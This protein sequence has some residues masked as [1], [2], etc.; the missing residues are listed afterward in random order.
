MEAFELDILMNSARGKNSSKKEN[1]EDSVAKLEREM[2]DDIRNLLRAIGN[3]DQVLSAS[4]RAFQKL[5]KEC[6]KAVYFTLRK[7]VEKEKENALLHLEVMNKFE[8]TVLEI[9]V[10]NDINEFIKLNMSDVGAMELSSQALSLLSDLTPSHP[11]STSP[12][13]MSGSSTP[14]GSFSTPSRGGPSLT[15]SNLH[16]AASA[17]SSAAAMAGDSF[18]SPLRNRSTSSASS[19]SSGH[20]NAMPQYHTP[21]AKLFAL[22]SANAKQS[23]GATNDELASYLTQIFYCTNATSPVPNAADSEPAAAAAEGDSAE[24]TSLT[25][26]N[27]ASAAGAEAHSKGP[28][29]LAHPSP[30][31]EEDDAD[32]EPNINDRS[33][34]DYMKYK[35]SSLRVLSIAA[36]PTAATSEAL[37]QDLEKKHTTTRRTSTQPVTAEEAAALKAEHRKAKVNTGDKHLDALSDKHSHSAG[38]GWLRSNPDPSLVEAVEWMCRAV[39]SQSGR[40]IFIAEL[41]Q[42]RSKKVCVQIGV[43]CE[44]VLMSVV[45]G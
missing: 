16:T 7:I 10:D 43:S 45:A 34:V 4:R 30:S 15:S 21:A 20:V 24:R 38:Y 25:E 2:K 22:E 13:N 29:S 32:R 33:S 19:G 8:K 40:D 44:S 28:P 1:T 11:T 36:T 18:A 23:P 42:F 41:N 14:R 35:R 39:K 5:D 9:D 17:S 3:K 6:K 12:Q 31:F 37:A 26:L 27:D